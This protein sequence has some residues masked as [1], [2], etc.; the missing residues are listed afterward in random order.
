MISTRA[1]RKAL[2]VSDAIAEIRRCS[3]TQ[4]DPDIVPLDPDIVLAFLACQPKIVMPGDMSL[5]KEF[6]E[7]FLA[8]FR[9]RID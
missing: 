6:E 8:L 7:S 2:P 1:Y 4:L 5:P 3:G 9:P